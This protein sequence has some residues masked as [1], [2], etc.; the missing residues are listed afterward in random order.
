MGGGRHIGRRRSRLGGLLRAS[1]GARARR[2]RN[3]GD[4]V[5]G[6]P[7]VMAHRRCG[8]CSCSGLGFGVAAG[9]RLPGRPFVPAAFAPEHFAPVRRLG[10]V[11]RGR[12]MAEPDRA[13][14][15]ASD[16]SRQRIGLGHPA[17][18]EPDLSGVR[19]HD[20]GDHAD[21]CL[22]VVLRLP[23]LRRGAEAQ[24]WRL[25]RVLL[26]WGCEVPTDPGRLQLLRLAGTA[27][28]CKVS[29]VAMT[30]EITHR[31][32]PEVALRRP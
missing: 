8:A 9:S 5:A 23:A 25:L 13:Q 24:A 31:S 27:S 20:D 18:L 2:N 28:S 14:A 32:A 6:G 19:A 29:G 3:G 11:G 1:N 10:P 30:F 12:R 4:G 7:A 26:L 16:P 15:V 22:P 21:R 17:D